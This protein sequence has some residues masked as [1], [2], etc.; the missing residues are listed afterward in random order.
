MSVSIYAMIKMINTTDG[1][2]LCF[3]CPSY[4]TVL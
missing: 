4:Y 3:I 1:G 2:D